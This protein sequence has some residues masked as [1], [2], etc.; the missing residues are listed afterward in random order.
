MEFECKI[1]ETP[2]RKALRHGM[3]LWYDQSSPTKD[4]GEGVGRGD[5]ERTITKFVADRIEGKLGEVAFQQT[6]AEEFGVE[7]TVDWS[8]YGDIEVTDEADLEGIGPDGEYS[9][10]VAF[11]VK[12]TKPKNLWMAVRASIWRDHDDTDP[13]VLAKL[14]LPERVDLEPWADAGTYPDDDP[15]FEQTVTEWCERHL[16][17]SASVVGFAEKREFTDF[18][19]RGERLYHPGG[20]FDIGPHLK[21]DNRGVPVEELR[22]SR[23][24][25]NELVE[26]IVG[27]APVDWQPL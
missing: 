25:W 22:S 14:E 1:G 20:G 8:V 24:A 16:P 15:A 10:G 2:F 26:R 11:D 7:S 13:F 27:D 23:S 12:K 17:V 3:E 6:L 9:P 19:E 4:W 5:N 21:T 18:F